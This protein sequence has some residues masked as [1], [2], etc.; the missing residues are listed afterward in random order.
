MNKRIQIILIAI[1]A[2]ATALA[3]AYGQRLTSKWYWRNRVVKKFGPRAHKLAE[4]TREDLVTNFELR[5]LVWIHSL[6]VWP[7]SDDGLPEGYEEID[8]QATRTA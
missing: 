3:I 7:F 1:L 8:G 4:W 2:I 6:E 5:D